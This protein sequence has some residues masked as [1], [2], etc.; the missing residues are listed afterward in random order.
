MGKAVV[1]D[2]CASP[3][4]LLHTTGRKRC[5]RWSSQ[6]LWQIARRLT[7]CLFVAIIAALISTSSSAASLHT[8]TGRVVGI[9][10]GDTIDVLSPNKQRIRIRLAQIDAPEHG[11]PWG[12]R[13]KQALSAL[14]YGKT[15]QLEISALDRYG[16]EIANVYKGPLDV[17]RQMVRMGDAWAYR[18]YLTDP[19]LIDVETQA[20]EARLGLWSSPARPVPPWTWRH[21][22]HP[23]V[24]A[25]SGPTTARRSSGSLGQLCGAKRYCREMTSCAEA[26]FYLQ[27]CGVTRLDGDGDGV[28]CETL[29]RR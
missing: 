4:E 5:D 2:R 6:A 27:Q 29:C 9:I 1:C 26:R 13:S 20:R 24:I 14:V 23:P 18:Q 19:S 10:D 22:P 28:P 8:A 16:R 12:Q 11:Q 15:V 21:G 3:P 17:N 25:T 7:G